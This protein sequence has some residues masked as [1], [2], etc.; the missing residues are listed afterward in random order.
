MGALSDRIKDR[1][2]T[3]DAGIGVLTSAYYFAAMVGPLVG[4]VMMGD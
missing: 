2:D 3:T 4:G 1:F